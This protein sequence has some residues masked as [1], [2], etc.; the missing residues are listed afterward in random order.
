MP[1]PAWGCQTKMH[2]IMMEGNRA[3][4]GETPVH[5]KISHPGLISNLLEPVSCPIF[6][7]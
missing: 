2:L 3:T 7:L 1:T 4:G 5:A 6:G